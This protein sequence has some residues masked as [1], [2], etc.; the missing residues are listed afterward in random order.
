M[1]VGKPIIGAIDG[2]TAEVIREAGCGY[3][4]PADDA[5]ALVK[6][7]KLFMDSDRKQQMGEKARKFYED[8]FAR[9]KFMDKLEEEL[10]R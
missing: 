7:I 5:D 3:C 10:K 1:A 6:N 2:E 9:E 8:F 4:G